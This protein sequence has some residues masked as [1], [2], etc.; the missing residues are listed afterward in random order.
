[1]NILANAI[2]ALEQDNEGRSSEEIKANP[3]QI[4]I[5]TEVLA[6][7]RGVT[8]RINDNG[9]G[10]P[11]DIQHRIFDHMFTTKAVGKGTGLGLSIAH[12]I[13]VDKHE[14]KLS[15]NSV[16][17]QGSEFVIELPIA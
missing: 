1:M 4:K 13:V 7:G 12:Q 16:I 8:I 11:E 17:G 14:G 6:D 3:N 9:S 2:D 5:T 15:C 10:I